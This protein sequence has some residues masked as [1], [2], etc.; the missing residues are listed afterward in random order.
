MQLTDFQ[1]IIA[2]LSMALAG[3]SGLVMGIKVSRNNR[4]NAQDRL[5][6]GLI[7]FTSANAMFFALAPEALVAAGLDAGTTKFTLNL[8]LAAIITA[9][10]VLSAVSSVRSKP[11]Y[12]WSFWPLWGTGFVLSVCL[13]WTTFTRSAADFLPLVLIWLLIVAFA[14]FFTFLVLTWEHNRP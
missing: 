2:E 9:S 3:F 14:Q 13:A 10:C 1:S 4:W 12:P 7:L 5:G 11:R 6:L 8:A